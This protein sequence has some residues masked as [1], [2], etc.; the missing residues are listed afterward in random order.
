M[1]ALNVTFYSFGGV[2]SFQISNYFQ[3]ELDA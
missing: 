1:V 3:L 2:L